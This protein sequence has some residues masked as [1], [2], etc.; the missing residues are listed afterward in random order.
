M[1]FNICN[2]TY[3]CVY[4]LLRYITIWRRKCNIYGYNSEYQCTY[5]PP[6]WMA[7]P[8]KRPD[9]DCWPNHCIQ[10]HEFINN[11]ISFIY[12][13]C[14]HLFETVESAW[15]GWHKDA[16]IPNIVYYIHTN[17]YICILYICFLWLFDWPNGIYCRWFAPFSVSIHSCDC[18]SD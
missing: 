2:Y 5:A 9:D 15:H 4:T 14:T 6:N 1:H 17:I 7:I 8:S 10:I 16:M 18:D 12:S 11:F 3:R 13:A